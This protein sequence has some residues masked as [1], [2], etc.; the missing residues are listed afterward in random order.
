MGLPS[1]KPI[2]K[3]AY[4]PG[5]PKLKWAFYPEM[6]LPHGHAQGY[7]GL[8]NQNPDLRILKFPKWA[9]WSR[10]PVN[11]YTD[12]W[13]NENLPK[14]GLFGKIQ[15]SQPMIRKC[16]NPTWIVGGTRPKSGLFKELYIQKNGPI[17]SRNVNPI[18][19]GWSSDLPYI[20]FWKSGFKKSKHHLF[21][22]VPNLAFLG[23]KRRNYWP[24]AR[25]E[26]NPDT[27]KKLV[28]SGLTLFPFP[29]H[30]TGS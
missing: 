27:A 29:L 14:S 3:W 15:K 22:M 4:Y 28:K 13:L 6:L 5:K 1:R 23:K 17:W 30:T 10:N 11:P 26:R 7:L 19:I 25:A 12:F 16:Q 9:L 24:R 20:S 21:Q 18:Q 2:L 8:S